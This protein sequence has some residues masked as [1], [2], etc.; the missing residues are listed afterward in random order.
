[1]KRKIVTM[2][3]TL[4]T[5]ATLTGCAVIRITDNT[6]SAV[7]K[8]KTE[9]IG[10]GNMTDRTTDNIEIYYTRTQEDFD[11]LTDILENRNGK[12]IIEISEGV[13]LDAV[14][15]G[16]DSLGNYIKYGNSFSVGDIMQSVFVYNPENNSVDDIVYRYDY[17]IEWYRSKF[18]CIINNIY[19]W[20][21]ESK[22]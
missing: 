18:C 8:M 6:E 16:A 3:L 21:T 2:I 19:S 9:E 5:V 12:I 22:K 11:R 17:L 10:T 7:D 20:K 4:V 15:N 14:G 13:V 1:M